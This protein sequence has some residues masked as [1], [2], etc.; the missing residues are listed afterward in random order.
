MRFNPN[1]GKMLGIGICG[2]MRKLSHDKEVWT[3][4]KLAWLR[5][6]IHYESVR[7]TGSESTWW[8]SGWTLR[9]PHRWQAGIPELN[10]H[11]YGKIIELNITVNQVFH[12]NVWLPEGNMVSTVRLVLCKQGPAC[13]G[14]YCQIVLH[15]LRILVACVLQCCG[16]N[17][18]QNFHG[19]QKTAHILHFLDY[20]LPCFT[21]LFWLLLVCC[22]LVGH[23]PWIRLN[24]KFTGLLARNIYFL[25]LKLSPIIL[26]AVSWF[27]GKHPGNHRF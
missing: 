11:L 13:H 27:Q 4:N 10:W 24:V 20:I 14:L 19:H 15:S 9:S 7:V 2:N 1:L 3:I 25:F 18:V 12:C 21:I 17:L 22:C 26:Y 5:L 16:S 6:Q 8:P 23:I